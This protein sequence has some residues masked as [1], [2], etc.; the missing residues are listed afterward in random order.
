MSGHPA[1]SSALTEELAA[2]FSARPVAAGPPRAPT[3]PARTRRTARS[4]LRTAVRAPVQL[5]LN[6][7]MVAELTR[8]VEAV[9]AREMQPADALLTQVDALEINAELLKSELRA[10]N[11]N[12]E[13]LTASVEAMGAAIAPSAGIEGVPERM[14]ELRERLNAVERR[15]RRPGGT[16]GEAARPSASAPPV[17]NRPLPSSP[18]DYVGFE[19]RFR[20]DPARV[21]AVIRERYLDLLRDHGPVLDVGCGKG[22]LVETL[23][24]A[25]VAARGIDID[26]TMAEEAVAKGLDVSVSDLN[27]HLEKQQPSSLGAIVSIQVVEHLQV[28]DLVRF[29]ELSASRLTPGGVFIAETPNPTSLIVLGNSFILDPT[30]VRPIHPSLMVYLCECA[31]F[32][33]VD[34]LFFEPALDYQLPLISDEGAPG[35]PVINAAFTKLN[36]VLFGP[37]DY[38]VVART[39]GPTRTGQ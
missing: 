14:A 9:R 4:L 3:F 2:Q 37:Q 13:H 35:A 24:A 28:P 30:H 15:T 18:I 8:A 5:Y 11:R 23:T 16:S 33:S 38:A 31:G 32:R 36:N 1:F 25:G 39:P 10:V 22:E 17:P 27:E 21:Q 34:I 6:R 12:L 19:R 26:P 7:V 29:L 20:G